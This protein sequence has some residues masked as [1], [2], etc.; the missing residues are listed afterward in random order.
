[1][2]MT[3]SAMQV[4][5]SGKQSSRAPDDVGEASHFPDPAHDSEG[6]FSKLG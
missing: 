6:M 3:D 4:M 5:L 2:S 1:M